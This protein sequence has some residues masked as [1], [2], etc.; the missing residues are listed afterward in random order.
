MK[1]SRKS[2]KEQLFQQLSIQNAATFRGKYLNRI[3]QQLKYASLG[4]RFFAF[5]ID[6]VCSSIFITLMPMLI[7]SI[8]TQEKS[9]T[10]RS[11]MKLPM[12]LQILC[13][14]LA[15]SAAV[16]YYCIYPSASAH[17]G[18]TVGKRLMHIKIQK[19]DGGQIHMTDLLKRE[20]IG[21]LLLEGETAFPS[22][23]VRY[24]VFLWIPAILSRGL[25]ITSVL[26][27]LAFIIWCVIDQR[28]CMFHDLIAKTSVVDM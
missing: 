17:N 12:P 9:F 2:K 5:L 10:T 22:A 3:R 7:T 16:Y 24:L 13:C 15:V 8:I 19:Q 18:Q 26:I 6:F 28:R 23:F 27:S 11:L 4:R 14:L 1:E 20:L 25:M 21:S